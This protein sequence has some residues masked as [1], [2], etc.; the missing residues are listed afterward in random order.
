MKFEELVFVAN[1]KFLL[2]TKEIKEAISPSPTDVA[3][4][5]HFN[6]GKLKVAIRRPGRT[7]NPD[8][9]RL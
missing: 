3:Y 1:E 6:E 4:A 7:K 2:R 8:Q 5:V 9:R